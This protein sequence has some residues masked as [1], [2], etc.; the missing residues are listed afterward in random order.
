M[1]IGAKTTH[2]VTIKSSSS[3]LATVG[4]ITIQAVA[5]KVP[6]KTHMNPITSGA[7]LVRKL[8]RG[9]GELCNFKAVCLAAEPI[10]VY[11]IPSAKWNRLM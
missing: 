9:R 4:T 6:K 3:C 1:M 5:S 2:C 10:A 7:N 8:R 11:P